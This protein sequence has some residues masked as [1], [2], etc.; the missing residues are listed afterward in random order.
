MACSMACFLMAQKLGD[1]GWDLMGWAYHA[2]S[3]LPYGVTY[4][5][6]WQPARREPTSLLA[7][8]AGNAEQ[9]PGHLQ[10]EGGQTSKTS[11]GAWSCWV[12]SAR[13]SSSSWEST[14]CT[15]RNARVQ[16]AGGHGDRACGRS[17]RPSRQPERVVN[18][19]ASRRV[20]CVPI[21]RVIIDRNA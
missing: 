11:R 18:P 19:K 12:M 16:L 20:G 3:R 7:E 5:A 8:I 13:R 15:A 10:S 2:A 21:P 14:I 17:V 1:I 6:I 9:S 4:N